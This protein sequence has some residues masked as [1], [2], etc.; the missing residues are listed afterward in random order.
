[1]DSRTQTS[2]EQAEKDSRTQ[3]GDEQWSKLNRDKWTLAPK[4]ATSNDPN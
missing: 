3:T 2:D 4:P 1:M